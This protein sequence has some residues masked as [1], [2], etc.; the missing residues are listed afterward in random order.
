MAVLDQSASTESGRSNQ[1][2]CD[3]GSMPPRRD[4]RQREHVRHPG[5]AQAD[6][7]RIGL[8]LSVEQR[9]RAGRSR[10]IDNNRPFRRMSRCRLSID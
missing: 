7:L 3:D 10:K 2:S 6:D 8:G 9:K 1:A 5:L 4:R